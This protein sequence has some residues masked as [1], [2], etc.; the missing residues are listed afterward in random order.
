MRSEPYKHQE[1]FAKVHIDKEQPKDYLKK[2]IEANQSFQTICTLREMGN[3]LIQTPG[4]VVFKNYD[5]QGD[6][7]INIS[8][9]KMQY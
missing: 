6:M 7:G 3:K 1:G 5:N 4:S 2:R 9:R 8:E